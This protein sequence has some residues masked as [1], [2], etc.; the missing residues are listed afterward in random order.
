MTVHRREIFNSSARLLKVCHHIAKCGGSDRRGPPPFR[1]F[2]FFKMPDSCSP[3]ERKKKEKFFQDKFRPSLQ[4][5]DR[6][7]KPSKKGVCTKAKR[8][9]PSSPGSSDRSIWRRWKS[10]FSLCSIRKRSFRRWSAFNRLWR[11]RWIRS[12]SLTTTTT[13]LIREQSG[14]FRQSRKT[15]LMWW[16]YLAQMN[17]M[18]KENWF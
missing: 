14:G 5:E 7:W 9:V 6:K 4:G 11:R 13:P 3:S 16:K 12:S 8:S 2:P 15:M 10:V 1:V 18:W 17:Y